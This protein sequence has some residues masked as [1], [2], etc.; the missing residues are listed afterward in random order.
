MGLSTSGPS[1]L[2]LSAGDHVCAF[3]EGTGLLNEIVAD[4]ATKALQARDKC[5][6]FVDEPSAV[7]EKIPL[8]L[9]SDDSAL[10]FVPEE[11]GYLAQGH[12]SKDIFINNLEATARSVLSSGYDRLWLVGDASVI[13]RNAVDPKA[14]FAAEA[15]VSDLAPKYPQFIMCLYDLALYDGDLVMYVLKTHTKLFVN[16]LIINNPY[17]LSKTQFLAEL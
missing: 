9:A 8:D 3:Y 11:E 5:I 17:Y 2:A 7:K 15:E 4:F 12:F 14:W 1:D 6:C 13:V 10:Q 16:G